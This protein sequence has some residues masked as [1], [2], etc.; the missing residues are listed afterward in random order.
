MRTQTQSEETRASRSWSGREGL[1]P[2]GEGAA[3]SAARR[4]I[5]AVLSHPAP[6]PVRGTFS[7][8]ASSSRGRRGHGNSGF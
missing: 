8:C 2:R 6:A 3:S 4:Y 7:G 1:S 5:S